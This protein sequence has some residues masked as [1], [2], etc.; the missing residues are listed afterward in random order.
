MRKLAREIEAIPTISSTN[1]KECVLKSIWNQTIQLFKP[2]YL[3]P[4]LLATF[5]QIS[6][7][8]SSGGLGLWLPE[9]LNRFS[10]STN[11]KTLCDVI[12][13]V[14][15]NSFLNNTEFEVRKQV[16][17]STIFKRFYNNQFL[18]SM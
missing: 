3:L 10:G 4:F 11:G 18:A 9:L 13:S 16:T 15:K 2:P 7:F 14:S 8:T 1:Q 17:N 6:V 5:M 12:T